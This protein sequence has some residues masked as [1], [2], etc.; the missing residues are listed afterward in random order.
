M[1]AL[2]N[3]A[4]AE[5]NTAYSRSGVI[6]GVRLVYSGEVAGYTE[7]GDFSTDLSRLRSP[8]DGFMDNVHA[9]RNAFGADM[10]S[11]IIEGNGSLCGLG[12]LMLTESAGFAANAFSVSARSCATG[13]YTFSHEMGHNM[14]LQHDRIAQPAN[15]VFPH[16]HGYV[17]VVNNFRDIMG[18]ASGCGGCPRIQNF[19]NP[20]VTHNGFPTGVPIAAPNS[21]DAAA[22]LNATALTVANW[23]TQVTP[24]DFGGDGKSDIAVY[25]SGAWFIQNSSGGSTVVE[26]GGA[27]QDIPVQEDYDGDGKV[28]IAIFRDGAWFIVKS[29]GGT[30]A[31][32][33]GAAGDILV[34]GDY[35]GDGKTDQ[36]VYRN[37]AWFILNSIGG[38]TAVGWGGAPQDI[39]VPADYDGDGKTDMA[40]YRN[41]AWFI[42]KSSGGTQAVGWGGAP[43]DIPVPADYD[44]DGMTDIAIY[45]SGAWYILNSSGG[46]Q[47]IGWG[48]APQDIPVP[49]D[50]DG[51][52]KTDVAVF[53]D[54]AWYINK[55]SGGTQAVGWGAAG[56]IPIN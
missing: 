24:G 19:S 55:S 11:L 47:A 50:Y 16:S 44:G 7:A 23:R 18:V 45:R 17:D 4:V 21:A 35:D 5:T 40:I 33:W 25:R 46:T 56:D 48:G 49:A 1:A 2:V 52:G 20:N 8:S 15:G 54:G 39:P 30:S 43:Q 31:I 14:G 22:S 41:G 26:W 29:S 51:D 37:G 36:A 13:N 10:V 53:R 32:G 12:Y 34:P 6:P 28:D 3:L 9:L 38:V 42:V 27:V